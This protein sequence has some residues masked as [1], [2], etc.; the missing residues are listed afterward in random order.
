MIG[1]ADLML[2]PSR[3]FGKRENVAALRRRADGA[4]GPIRNETRRLAG[5]D[6]AESCKIVPPR[7]L[8]DADANCP[9]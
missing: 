2:R 9:K 7:E 8:G 6:A 5:R 1:S 3:D 4:A